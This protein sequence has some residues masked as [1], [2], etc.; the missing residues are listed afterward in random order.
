MLLIGLK[1]LAAVTIAVF[2]YGWVNMIIY[3]YKKS[4][5]ILIK[6]TVAEE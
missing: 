1:L 3:E 6:G 2:T 5:K 4:Y